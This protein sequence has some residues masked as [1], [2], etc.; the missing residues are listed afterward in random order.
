LHD[1]PPSGNPYAIKLVKTFSSFNGRP[2]AWVDSTA[3]GRIGIDVNICGGAAA[4][5]DVTFA[6]ARIRFAFFFVV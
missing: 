6:L 4:G 3:R 2:L 5:A 1:S